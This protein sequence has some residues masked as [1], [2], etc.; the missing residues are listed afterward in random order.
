MAE[1]FYAR[2]STK[3][4]NLARQQA[5]ESVPEGNVYTDRGSGKNMDRKALQ[6]LLSVLTAGDTLYVWS[7]DRLGRNIIDL[8]EMVELFKEKHVTVHFM[9]ER[10]IL[11]PSEENI[12]QE[13]FFG[14]MAVWAN[15][16]RRMILRSQKQGIERAKAEGKFKGSSKRIDR[17]AV[18]ALHKGG[19]KQVAI[20]NIMNIS[21]KSVSNILK[22]QEHNE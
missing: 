13:A 6:S 4:Q 2:V 21:Q 20:A 15:F 8:L 12:M 16:Q 17:T 18:W 3:E 7:I 10:Q 22:E 1:Y 5:P 9:E 11:D 19:M 14:Q